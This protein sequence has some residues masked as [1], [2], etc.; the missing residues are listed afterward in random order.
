M[1]SLNIFILIIGAFSLTKKSRDLFISIKQHNK[2]KI[3]ADI[4]FLVLVII[5]TVG[6]LSY[7][8]FFLD[9]SRS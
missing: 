6:L 5:L 8:H 9:G 3:K 7:V 4:L 1:S 2:E